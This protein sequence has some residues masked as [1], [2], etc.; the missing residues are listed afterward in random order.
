MLAL[1]PAASAQ[2]LPQWDP[3]YQTCSNVPPE[4]EHAGS[5]QGTAP[6]TPSPRGSEVELGLRDKF[7]EDVFDVYAVVISP[8]G[9]I[10]QGE[11]RTLVA[12]DWALLS[13][14][15]D[16]IGGTT[17]ELGPYTIIWQSDLG[18]IGCDGF[19]IQPVGGR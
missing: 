6:R 17:L 3:L 14:P 9:R 8:S 13:Y 18:Y 10:A 1:A 5:W 12:D 11:P 7:G 16:F 4:A 19:F 2:P 15:S